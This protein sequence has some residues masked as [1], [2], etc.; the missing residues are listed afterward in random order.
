[1]F[2]AINYQKEICLIVVFEKQKRRE[3]YRKDIGG[4]PKTPGEVVNSGCKK[5]EQS[6]CSKFG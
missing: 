6:A 1:V 5:A 4:W 3:R 2:A